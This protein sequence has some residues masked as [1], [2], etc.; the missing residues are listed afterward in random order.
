M[1]PPRAR[2]RGGVALGVLGTLLL[3]FFVI[4]FM[5]G[6]H[7]HFTEVIENAIHDPRLGH[8]DE[9]ITRGAPG[10]V[11]N[12]SMLNEKRPVAVLSSG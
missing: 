2:A 4:V 6:R 11:G 3:A 7:S 1:P 8:H 9:P 12:S 10:A 5:L